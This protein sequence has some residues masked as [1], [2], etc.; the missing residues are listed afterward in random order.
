MYKIVLTIKE[1][2]KVDEKEES[3]VNVNIERK[4]NEKS[5]DLEKISGINIYNTIVDTLQKIG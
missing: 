5:T 4:G 1:N 3:K 2:K